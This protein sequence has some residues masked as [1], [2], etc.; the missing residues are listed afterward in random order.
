M[1]TII[2]LVP[3][4]LVALLIA[5]L[6]ASPALAARGGGTNTPT[7]TLTTA[8]PTAAGETPHAAV[9]EPVKIE[10]AGYPRN[11]AV[12]VVITNSPSLLVTTDGSG[13]FVTGTSFSQP[14][15]YT[16]SACYL[17]KSGWD[18]GSVS[19]KTLVVVVE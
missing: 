14:G 6:S 4:L 17:K 8:T 2:R 16:F 12:F 15:T 10:G 18:C 3:I 11:T 13:W 1:K 19:P 5:V 7:L 9:G